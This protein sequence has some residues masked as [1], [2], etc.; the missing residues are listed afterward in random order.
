MRHTRKDPPTVEEQQADIKR[1][2]QL[3]VLVQAAD[4]RWASKDSFLKPPEAPKLEKG[5]DEIEAEG[6]TT[7]T[8]RAVEPKYA[9][10]SRRRKAIA[11]NEFDGQ[12]KTTKSAS[13]TNQWKSALDSG[14][15][16]E[17]W[18]PEAWTPTPARKP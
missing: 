2:A 3:K 7:T 12:D 1:L 6:V 8:N 15:P 5:E 17:R 18:Q 10:A 13:R 4:E 16:G 14:G 9:S 11:S